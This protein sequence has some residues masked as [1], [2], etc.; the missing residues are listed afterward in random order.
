[1]ELSR[2]FE[3]RWL[4]RVGSEMPTRRGLGKILKQANLIQPYREAYT[5]RGRRI[6][7]LALYWHP[8]LNLVIKAARAGK[9]GKGG[10][11]LVTVLTPETEQGHG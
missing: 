2:H 9:G 4:E 10:L 5:P 11:R 8:G 3:E 6:T 1:M 7:F